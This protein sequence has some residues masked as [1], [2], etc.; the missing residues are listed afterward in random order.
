MW[1]WGSSHH[2]LARVRNYWGQALTDRRSPNE[3]AQVRCSNVV[4]EVGDLT[5]AIAAREHSG[6]VAAAEPR[7]ASLPPLLPLESLLARRYWERHH[8]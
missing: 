7:S 8:R 1:G 5:P 6:E 4:A 3:H 2:R